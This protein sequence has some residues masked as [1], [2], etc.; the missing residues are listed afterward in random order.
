MAHLIN[1]WTEKSFIV[2]QKMNMSRELMSQKIVLI[3]YFLNFLMKEMRLGLIIS[4]MTVGGEMK[5]YLSF[6]MKQAIDLEKKF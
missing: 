4:L 3:I 5:P 1:G 2:A 6:I